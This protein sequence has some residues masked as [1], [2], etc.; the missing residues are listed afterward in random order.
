[1][2]PLPLYG[3]GDYYRLSGIN[4]G[5]H[6]DK[7][8]EPGRLSFRKDYSR[9]IHTPAFRRLQGKTQLFPGYES[10]FF[11]N[12]LTHSL[13]VAQIS[14]GIGERI[15]SVEPEFES[16]HIDLDLL[17]FAGLAHDLGHPPFGHN[18]ER[19]LDEMML[20]F[21]GFEGNAQTLRILT[22]TERKLIKV[23]E[24]TYSD[25]GLDLTV[26]SLA[27]ILKYDT[28]IPEQR[29]KRAPLQKGYY[30]SSADIV[31]EIKSKVAP[32]KQHQG[33][34]RTIEC[35]IMEIAD[36]IAYSTYDLEDSLHAGF[37]TPVSILSALFNDGVI[38]KTVFDRT[39]KELKKAKHEEMQSFDELFE[40]ASLVFDGLTEAGFSDKTSSA[41]EATKI[42]KLDQQIAQDSLTRTKFTAERVGKLIGSTEVKYNEHCPALSQARL[43]REAMLEVEILKHLN[44][45]LNIRSPRLAVVEYRGKD[46]V[47][48]LFK[49]IDNSG[50][51]L[52]PDDWKQLY[53]DSR[54]KK[55]IICDFIAGMTDRYATEFHNSLF[56][57][58][59]SLFKPI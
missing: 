22:C 35:S 59:K 21:G 24:N 33:D 58:G 55:R 57:S 17:E 3:D 32:R 43:T 6:C 36:D 56:G 5:K 1:M 15:N 52:L 50:G 45:E 19:A 53:R 41:L 30:S 4:V 2:K 14:T 46:I 11:R 48:E 29:K 34:F 39:N 18:G 16:S 47:C 28:E 25:L 51:S 31:K 8:R 27:S 20:A 9:L 23:G 12:R 49:A 54:N 10:D 42:Y 37:S 40:A 26:R 13:E 38:R 7:E 44:Y